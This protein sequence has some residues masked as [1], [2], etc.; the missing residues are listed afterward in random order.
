[1]LFT[2]IAI[3]GLILIGK[4][5]FEIKQHGVVIS[6]DAKLLS[7]PGQNYQILSFVPEASEVN[8]EKEADGFYKIKFN[9]NIGWIN[10][11]FVEK[12]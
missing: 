3:F 10:R 4:Y 5:N 6:K 8:I 7:G 9:S 12:F 11:T 2:T 1:M